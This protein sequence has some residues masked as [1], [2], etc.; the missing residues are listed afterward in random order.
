VASGFTVFNTLEKNCISYFPLFQK[1]K[2]KFTKLQSPPSIGD[3]LRNIASKAISNKVYILLFSE[4]ASE[5]W[6]RILD[7]NVIAL[8]SC[9]REALKSMKNRGV[10]DGHIIHINR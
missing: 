9:T 10:D 2:W 1:Y 3:L 4:A 5:D 6:R 8:S 7:V